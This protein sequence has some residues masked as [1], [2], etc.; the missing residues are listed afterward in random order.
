MIYCSFCSSIISITDPFTN[1]KAANSNMSVNQTEEAYVRERNGPVS[2]AANSA[3]V[4]GEG[5]TTREPAI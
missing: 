3:V 4:V 2:K 5:G 1:T